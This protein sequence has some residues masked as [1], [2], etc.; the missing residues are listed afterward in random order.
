[1]RTLK[2]TS[3]YLHGADVRHLQQGLVKHGY[4]KGQADASYGPLTAQGTFRAKYWLGY[5]VPDQS[6]SSLLMDYLDGKKQT[7]KE[8]K[9][10]AAQRKKAKPKVPMR[11]KAYKWLAAH[12][13]DKEHPAGSNKIVWASTWYGLT[14]PWCAMAV[15]RAYVEAG[16]KGF[17][18]GRRWAYVPY[19][20]NAAHAGQDGLAITTDPKLGDIVTYD[21]EGGGSRGLADHVGLF[22]KWTSGRQQFQ[23]LEGNTS[24][25]NDSNGGEVMRRNRNRSQVVAFIH[26]AR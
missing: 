20:V 19:M 15:T 12:E 9:A 22:V 16:S 24:V 3:P 7:T 13:G 5:R 1:M 14:G 25:G 8:M 17:V 26:C 10:R 23:A 2:L 6:A 21:W 4:L 11:E 18:R